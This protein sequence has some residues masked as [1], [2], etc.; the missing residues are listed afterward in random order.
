MN[1]AMNTVMNNFEREREDDEI[2]V[3]ND[4]PKKDLYQEVEILFDARNQQVEEVEDET[5]AHK[6]TH[7]ARSRVKNATYDIVRQ[8]M[9]ILE[10]HKRRIRVIKYHLG[11][12]GSC[13]DCQESV[14]MCSACIKTIKECTSRLIKICKYYPED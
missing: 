7:E 5:E 6:S 10:Q 8:D 4:E 9:G 12:V 11:P 3:L 13:L 2:T 1:T 14:Y